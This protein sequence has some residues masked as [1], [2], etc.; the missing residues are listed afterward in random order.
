MY[1]RKVAKR[2]ML[3]DN[4][5][6]AAPGSV[7]QQVSVNICK[8]KL[9]IIREVWEMRV[10]ILTRIKVISSKTIREYKGIYPLFR[11]FVEDML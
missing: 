5:R 8:A 2:G 9:H 4:P 3:G 11:I 6:E 1:C 10:E 7:P